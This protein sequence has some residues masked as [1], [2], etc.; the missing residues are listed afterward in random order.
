[1]VSKSFAIGI[2]IAVIVVLI[3][4]IYFSQQVQQR[5]ALQNVQI[6]LGGINLK[7]LG[8]TS[9]ILGLSLNMYNPNNSVTATLDRT[10]YQ[11][12]ANGNELANG[13]I[14]NRYDIPP[15]STVTVPTDV[16]VSYIDS[17][18]AVFS[19]LKNGAVSWEM[20]GTAYV[21]MPILGTVSVPYDFQKT[22]QF[23]N[24]ANQGS[25][26]YQ[27]TNSYQQNPQY[28][29][30]TEQNTV[31]ASGNSI[32]QPSKQKTYVFEQLNGQTDVTINSGQTVCWT[33]GVYTRNDQGNYVGIPNAKVVRVGGLVD[34][35]GSLT[36]ESSKTL[37][38]DST[39]TFKSCAPYVTS[40][41]F[42]STGH[43][44]YYGNDQYEGSVGNW[45][46]QT[47]YPQQQQ[48]SQQPIQQPTIQTI[49]P[50]TAVNYN[51]DISAGT[52]QYL[53]FNI[54]CTS[55]MNLNFQVNNWNLGQNIVVTIMDDN[56]F[57]I[58]QNDPNT[59]N[60]SMVYWSNG[61]KGY[62]VFSS[63]VASGTYHIMMSNLFD[64]VNTKLGNIFV[65]YICS[66]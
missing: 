23:S 45:V 42:K 55:T 32:P 29:S 5:E 43:S 20:K 56:N 16:T 49:S 25:N 51:F 15:T 47:E 24:N 27:G 26:S 54:P 37:Q 64:H 36:Q 8:L 53:T 1:L 6:S 46:T 35:Q 14:P 50:V 44:T 52:L 11:L 38:M 58:T 21:E 40:Y 9:A 66:S 17:L 39:G 31:G 10:E 48:T 60:Y 4:G 34:S 3:V 63:P 18:G 59:H 65:S 28:Q 19:A 12:Y 13:E 62:D 41:Y 22:S 2:G 30:N 7:S 57:K 61:E 33:I